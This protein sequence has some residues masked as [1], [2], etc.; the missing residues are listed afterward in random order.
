[1]IEERAGLLFGRAPATSDFIFGSLTTITF[2][3]W[4]LAQE[5]AHLTASI[6]VWSVSSATGSD[7]YFRIL[8]L[9]LIASIRSIFN[10]SFLLMIIPLSDLCKAKVYLKIRIVKYKWGFKT[11]QSLKKYKAEISMNGNLNHCRF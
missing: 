5:G 1:M 7:L 2:Q 4:V 3:H 9:P 8:R 10:S 6:K 11:V